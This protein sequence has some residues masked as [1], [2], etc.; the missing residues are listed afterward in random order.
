[1]G[2]LG[3][4]AA[5]PLRVHHARYRRHVDLLRVTSAACTG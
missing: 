3:D 1:M 5:A 2:E 4:R